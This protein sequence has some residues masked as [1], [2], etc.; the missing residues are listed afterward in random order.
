MGDVLNLLD[1]AH[2]PKEPY[3]YYQGNYDLVRACQIFCVNELS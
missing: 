1:Q 2:S 3:I